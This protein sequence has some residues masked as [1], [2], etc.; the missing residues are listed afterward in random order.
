[1]LMFFGCLLCVVFGADVGAYVG[2]GVDRGVVVVIM[3]VAVIAVCV[4]VAYVVA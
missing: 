3:S 4:Y 1:M 2:L